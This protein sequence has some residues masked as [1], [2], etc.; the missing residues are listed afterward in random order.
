[1]T[2]LME[3]NNAI[4]ALLT[5]AIAERDAFYDDVASNSGEYYD[6][7]DE[8]IV[9]E[10]DTL[11]AKGRRALWPDDDNFLLAIL[12]DIVLERHRQD[13][14]WGG[15]THDD[16]LRVEDWWSILDEFVDRLFDADGN[17]AEDYCERL[18]KIVAVAVA[19]AQAHY[20]NSKPEQS[21]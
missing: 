5:S 4:K 19:A 2:M 17:V 7:D 6:D 14:R 1:M 10:M 18:I 9:A 20:R 21:Q 12:D 16:G 15:P 3:M 11:I 8:R 13:E